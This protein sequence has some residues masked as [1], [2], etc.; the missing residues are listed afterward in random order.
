MGD[1]DL[2]ALQAEVEA[3]RAE[4]AA[5][6]RTVPAL[7]SEHDGTPITWRPWTPAPLLSHV[8]AACPQCAHPGPSLLTFGLAGEKQKIRFQANRCPACRETRVYRREPAAYGLPRIILIAYHPP[9]SEV[10]GGR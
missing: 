8:D 2:A 9:R 1:A 7:P 5:Q 10:P 6:Q 3:L 4:L